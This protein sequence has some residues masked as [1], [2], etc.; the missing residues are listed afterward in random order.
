MKNKAS[1][2]FMAMAAAALTLLGSCS[3]EDTLTPDYKNPSACFMPAENDQ[4]EE[5]QLRRSFLSETG[6]YLLFND[7]LQHEFLGNDINGSPRYFTELL[8]ITYAVG[9]SSNSQANYTYTYLESVEQKQMMTN[10]LKAY[11]LP[12]LTKDLKPYSWFICN[13]INY[14]SDSYSSSASH[15]YATSNQR[16]VVLS[17]SYLIQRERTEEQKE[18]YAQR[19]LNGIVG[20]L[21]M[22]KSDAFTEFYKISAKYYG[23]DYMAFGY[24]SRPSTQVLMQMGFL[25]ST[26]ISSFPSMSTDLN[27]YALMVI[28][29]TDE[30]LAA[31]YASYPLVLQKAAIVRQVLISLGYV[32]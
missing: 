1:I 11:L 3:G 29:Y 19:I 5:A 28:Q 9:Q 12:H 30:Q 13:V 32:F 22:N 8:D 27:S 31:Q 26:A 24:D 15:P 2:T 17:G 18:K 25:S 6:S 10:F 14:Y 16:C 23:A 7:T 20:Q 21:A 4:S